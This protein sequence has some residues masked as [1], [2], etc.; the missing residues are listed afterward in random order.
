MLT[1]TS[2]VL[3]SIFESEEALKVGNSV[4]FSAILGRP[5]L[6]DIDS[7]QNYQTHPVHVKS[8]YFLQRQ[9][10]T[11]LS[12]TFGA[13]SRFQ[14]IGGSIFSGELRYVSYCVDERLK[15]SV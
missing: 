1:S 11:P 8:V 10:Y 13:T 6:T 15:L 12:I 5:T 9:T 14:G 2:T 7:L 3:Y 4:L